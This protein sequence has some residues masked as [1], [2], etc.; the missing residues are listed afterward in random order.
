M[1]SS[2]PLLLVA[3]LIACGSVSNGYPASRQVRS[4]AQITSV[5]SESVVTQ[6]FITANGEER[7]DRS[8]TIDT[9]DS[10]SKCWGSAFADDRWLML[11]YSN[12]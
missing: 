2:L 10:D 1:A 12:W 4:P 11:D 7:C 8:G 3:I 6:V 9:Q 5:A